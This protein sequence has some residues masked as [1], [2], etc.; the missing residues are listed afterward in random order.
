MT[1]VALLDA[2]Y[3]ISDISVGFVTPRPSNLA[4]G[5]IGHA[6][7]EISHSET[8]LAGTFCISKP[9]TPQTVI[10]SLELLAE[11]NSIKTAKVGGECRK[12]PVVQL[13][14]S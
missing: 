5:R 8:H 2:V 7:W 14:Q 4:E 12:L 13:R 9:L 3:D 1:S 11:E 6:Q 10:D